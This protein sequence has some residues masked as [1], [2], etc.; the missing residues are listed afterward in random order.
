MARVNS[1]MAQT[2]HQI[3]ETIGLF[4]EAAENANA[5]TEKIRDDPSLLL[6]GGSEDDQ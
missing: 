4:R 2:Q 5:F 3:I 1:I 6:L